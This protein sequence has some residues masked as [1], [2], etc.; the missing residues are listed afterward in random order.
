MKYL[1]STK[2][3]QYLTALAQTKHF[4]KAADLC[5]VTQSTLS[6]GIK[7]LEI[8]FGVALA[9]RTKR[10]VIM[11]PIGK[12][13]AEHAEKLI[14]DA[15]QMM[16]LTAADQG[17]LTSK[18]QLG[19]I[20]TIAP[21]L[22][23]KLLPKIRS[24]YPHLEL[25]LRETQTDVLVEEVL[26]GKI[27]I[28][29]LAL[30]ASDHK[31]VEKPLFEDPF[32]LLAPSN[33]PII[34]QKTIDASTLMGEQLLLLEEG[35]C[36]RDQAIEFCTRQGVTDGFG[37][38]GA[39]SLA[40]VSQMVAANFGLTLLPQMALD[41]EVG[42]NKSLAVRPFKSPQPTRTIGLIWRKTTP[43]LADFESLAQVIKST[44]V[45]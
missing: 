27:D 44:Q 22:L 16:A 40:T 2:Q 5:N 43:R 15:E 24:N 26:N 39:T 33:H 38:L 29:L 10:S 4:S 13:I 41:K 20:P 12:K 35:H 3:L 14:L 11:T 21:Y 1:P 37:T 30:P 42:S 34:K 25:A 31:L 45:I 36:F 6:A 17:P 18:L 9:E 8:I 7:E 32:L 23:P 19:V 28:A